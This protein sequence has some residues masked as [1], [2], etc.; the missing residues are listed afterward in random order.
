MLLTKYVYVTASGK[1]I[2]ILKQLKIDFKYLDKVE[3]SVKYLLNSSTIK[4]DV[5]CSICGSLKKIPYYKYNK[6]ILNG[7]YYSCIKCRGQKTKQTNKKRYNDEN[8]NNKEKRKT[9]VNKKYGVDNISQSE[10]IKER[11]QQRC[12]SFY[13]VKNISL[14]DEI[15][16]KKQNTILEKNKLKIK[17]LISYEANIYKIYCEECEKTYKINREQYKNRVKSKLPTCLNCYPIS[18]NKSIKE[19]LLFELIEKNYNGEIITSDRVLLDGKEIDIY[20]PELKIAFEFN[21]L[22]W[23]SE[24]FKSREYHKNKTEKLLKKEI[25]LYHIWEHEYD[26]KMIIKSLSHKLQDKEMKDIK[27]HLINF[28]GNEYII[29]DDGF[30]FKNEL[31]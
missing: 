15:Q 31:Q 4:V 9:T 28:C 23:H 27:K 3:I 17:N 8:Y 20:L 18:E 14:V 25:I 6:N 11:K 13:G 26:E 22:Y 1:Y 2:N 5:E 19:K 24:K 12:L 16:Q 7:G 30:N 10:T 29:Y 21:G